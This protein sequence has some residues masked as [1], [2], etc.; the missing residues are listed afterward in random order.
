MGDLGLGFD[1]IL[2][3]DEVMSLF[4]DNSQEEETKQEPED[5]E[6][7][8]KNDSEKED[9]AEVVNTGSF[10]GDDED[11]DD[12]QPESVGSGEKNNK[13]HKEDTASEQGS[14]TSPDFFSSIATACV[15]EGIFPDLD[16]DTIKSIKSAADLKE[17]FDKQIEAGLTEQ[18]L[19]IKQALDNGVEDSKI[20]QYETLL[21]YL[22]N[23]DGAISQEGDDADEARRRVIFQDYINKG[24]SKERAEKAV[25][26]AFEDGTDKE[27]AE[28]ALKSCKDF[29]KTGYKSLLDEAK[30]EAD[31]QVREREQKALRIKKALIDDDIK[32]LGD[33]EITKTMRQKAYDAISKPVYK[34]SETGELMTALQ[35]LEHDNGEEFMVKLGI[36]YVLTD[37]FKN[38]DSLINNKVKKEMKK[39]F[40][41]LERKIKMPSRPIGGDLSYVDNDGRVFLDKGIQLDI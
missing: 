10:F 4:G 21:N 7:S 17:A 9:T 25:N 27:E 37:G 20:R 16:E 38:V 26:K 2:G 18:Q 41:D 12:E 40:S 30:K 31:N 28:E 8:E 1:N 23:L 39:G 13:E 24:F 29:Y 6:S 19:R 33:M 15:E 32:F 22:D 3:D 5:N 35:K 36:M 34:D 14:G 11:E